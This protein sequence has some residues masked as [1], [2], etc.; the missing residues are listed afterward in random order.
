MEIQ[1][2]VVSNIQVL[3]LCG[4]FDSSTASGARLWLERA[5]AEQSPN[6]V[7]N[8]QQIS[9]LDSTALSTLVQGMKRARQNQGDMRL[10]NVQQKVRIIFELTRLDRVFEIYNS[11]DDAVRAFLSTETSS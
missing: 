2:R 1:S 3:E 8:L 9:F 11:E 10:C 7:I 6:I 4:S 5:T